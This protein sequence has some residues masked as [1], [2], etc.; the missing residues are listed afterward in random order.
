M[1]KNDNLSTLVYSHL[2]VSTVFGSIPLYG[3]SES[4]PHMAILGIPP[5]LSGYNFLQTQPLTTFFDV[6]KSYESEKLEKMVYVL[7][8]QVWGTSWDQ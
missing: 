5:T 7:R 4:A 3:S 8:G 6:L 1:K 2:I